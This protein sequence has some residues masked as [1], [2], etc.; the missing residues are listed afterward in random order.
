MNMKNYLIA[1]FFGVPA[2]ALSA[3]A[4]VFIMK[5]GSKYEGSILKENATSYTLEVQVT[6]SIKD[7]R[8]IA[9]KDLVKIEPAVSASDDFLA[10]SSQVPTPDMLS[11]S[12]YAQRIRGVE[13]FVASH[14]M[15]SKSKEAETI[16]ATLKEEANTINAG[17]I[18]LNGTIIPP[19][20]YRNNAYDI[21]ARIQESKIRKL[22][23]DLQHLEALR[24]F[25]DF[26]RDFRNTNTYNDLIPFINQ[27]IIS[28]LADIQQSL[29][30]LQTE[31]N[32]H[33]VGLTRM[34]SE[35]RRNTEQA[36]VQ[37]NSEL[38]KRFKTENDAKT[39]WLTTHPPYKPALDQTLTYGKQEQ[40]RLLATRSAP[41]VDGGKAFRNA[42]SL[43]QSKGRND[44]STKAAIQQ[45]KAAMLPD[46]YMTTLEAS[47]PNSQAT[48]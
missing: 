26:E 31:F 44:D 29:A 37:Q 11:A 14:R 7:E 39:P 32:Q 43:I 18:K 24:A 22:V 10:I 33:R 46:R 40:I 2:L 48:P 41:F 9:K 36:I 28:Y 13:K 25:N 17:G 12:D 1:I 47:S 30:N 5:D 8:I 27:V 6:K 15:T 34:R 16:L 42:M 35:D 19:A 38:E 45:A 4:D 21:D 23:K 3:V 20:E